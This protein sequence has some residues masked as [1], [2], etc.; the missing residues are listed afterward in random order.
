MIIQ[1]DPGPKAAGERL[2]YWTAMEK[3]LREVFDRHPYLRS[4]TL[5]VAQY[6]SDE[7]DDAV[8]ARWLLSQHDE[9]D[10]AGHW[11]A[12]ASEAWY[13]R[14]APK[15]IPDPNLPAGVDAEPLRNMLR[16]WDL[17][18]DNGRAIPRFAAW[19]HERGN[20]ENEDPENFSRCATAR[21][22]DGEIV[23]TYAPMLRPWLDGV[24]PEWEP[25]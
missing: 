12:R 10:V 16:R 14:P 21:M 6:W 1:N 20:Q 7:A 9:P 5:F 8:H 22:V 3:D 18:D 2:R 24:K 25:G 4:I 23:V 19:C 11:K 13:E 17:W 15:P